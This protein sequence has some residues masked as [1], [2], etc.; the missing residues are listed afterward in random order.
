MRIL[1]AVLPQKAI[2]PSFFKAGP[3]PEGRRSFLF[4]RGYKNGTTAT[5]YEKARADCPGQRCRQFHGWRRHFQ[6]AAEYGRRSFRRR[7]HSGLGHHGFRDVLHGEF[8]PHSVRHAPRPDGRHLYVCARRFRPVH[9]LY[10]RLGLLALPDFR[11]RRLRRHH[12]GRFKLF[13][14]S[15]FSGRKQFIFN[16]RRFTAD[17]VL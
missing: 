2:P 6:S 16:H 11:Q 4:E 3:M 5:R 9:G 8:I 1:N 14:P 10:H 12:D 13:L 17:L 7:R 15:L